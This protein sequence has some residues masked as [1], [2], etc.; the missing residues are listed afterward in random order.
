MIG[1]TIKG[2]I[3][4]ILNFISYFDN[5]VQFLLFA[6]STLIVIFIFTLPYR[7]PIV[8][9][10]RNLGIPA[11]LTYRIVWLCR[12]NPRVHIRLFIELSLIRSKGVH[13]NQQWWSNLASE[14][15]QWLDQQSPGRD[16][17]I[18]VE[19]C[20]DL[21]SAEFS[22]NIQHYLSF[23][24]QDR[25]RKFFGIRQDDMV[26]FVSMIHIREGY[27]A[28]I[29]FIT[30][31]QDR[32][33]EDWKKIMA[34]YMAAFESKD[35]QKVVPSELFQ[36]YTWLMWGPSYQINYDENDYKLI[37]Y[38]FGDES[39]S[40]QVVLRDDAGSRETWRVLDREFGGAHDK[41]T[42]GLYCG[43]TARI[44]DSSHYFTQQR[45]RF[46]SQALAFTNRLSGSGVH[47]IFEL[48]ESHSLT[49]HRKHTEYF[50]SAYLWLMFTVNDGN[51]ETRFNPK[52]TVI[53]FE[54]A[55]LADTGNYDFLLSCL[56]SKCFLHFSQ[57]FADPLSK[58]RSYSFCFAMN[59]DIRDRFNEELAKHRAGTD[60][61]ELALAYRTRVLAEPNYSL[62][63]VLDAFDAYFTTTESH[64]TFIEVSIKD[65]ASIQKLCEF[66][67]HIY[68]REFPDPN[69]RE[70]LDNMLMY[71]SK[72]QTRWYGQNN[73]HVTLMVDQH[74]RIVGG[75]I[76]DYIFKANCG[77]ME[78][79]AV[80][81]DH[82]MKGYG[83]TLYN[84][85]VSELRSDARKSNR[86]PLQFM[87]AEV[88]NPMYD[89]VDSEEDAIGRLHFWTKLGFE[90]LNFP[91]VQPALSPEK[92][93][94]RSL[95][96]TYRT[97]D[98][99]P[100]PTKVQVEALIPA[101]E[102]YARLAMRIEDPQQNTEIHEMTN[103]LRQHGEITTYSLLDLAPAKRRALI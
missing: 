62:D 35:A 87:L 29:T 61:P 93:V 5:V 8:T 60:N 73:Y 22:D 30:G 88:D 64:L 83:R 52:N 70:S 39:N 44:F 31:L 20:F 90:A 69:E 1:V 57:V 21:T 103:Y 43:L 28:P 25:A 2:Y 24:K 46:P 51:P 48:Q 66:Y 100:K 26:S 14:F 16:Y 80:N 15:M 85:V 97:Y 63:E 3:D 96:L 75:A 101:I 68:L 47:F 38:G 11:V 10:L 56:M 95:V 94:V 71:L 12:K 4:S 27:L 54:H 42:F 98:E 9:T 45:A 50:F 74:Q 59:N 6:G 92:E 36:S 72:K 53:F 86:K 77:V 82:R 17:T 102:E 34:N 55:N 40:I 65:D 84:H 18:P 13:R 19:S 81:A 49:P 7:L 91:Y 37:Q 58:N 23:L 76:Y 89:H 78:F 99:L 33:N 79:M 41:S 67:A 32:Y